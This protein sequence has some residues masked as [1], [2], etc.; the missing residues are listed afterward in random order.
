[1]IV[2]CFCLKDG[3]YLIN[4]RCLKEKLIHYIHWLSEDISLRLL[5]QYLKLY[6]IMV[7]Y[8]FPCN[9]FFMIMI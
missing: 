1:M 6:D 7:V 8:F 2:F 9:C 3:T 5:G 4:S